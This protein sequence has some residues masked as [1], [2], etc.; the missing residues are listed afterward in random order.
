VVGR[1]GEVRKLVL[2]VVLA[3]LLLDTT[4]TLLKASSGAETLLEA[5]SEAR[6]AGLTEG[7]AFFLATVLVLGGILAIVVSG[8][9]SQKTDAKNELEKVE[10]TNKTI[11]TNTS[12]KTDVV[13]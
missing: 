1:E 6:T 9:I 11:F 5:F 3:G 2:L 8:A 10:Q 7:I 13:N 4:E 12:T